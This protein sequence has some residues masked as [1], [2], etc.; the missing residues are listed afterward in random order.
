[1]RNTDRQSRPKSNFFFFFLFNAL[2]LEWATRLKRVAS[3]NAHWHHWSCNPC[4]TRLPSLDNNN[5]NIM[6]DILLVRE[7]T[8]GSDLTD[9]Q[10]KYAIRIYFWSY[11]LTSADF[12]TRECALLAMWVF[13]RQVPSLQVALAL[14]LRDRH[15]HET[16]ADNMR[17]QHSTGVSGSPP[18]LL[19]ASEKHHCNHWPPQHNL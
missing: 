10:I 3:H 8:T 17:P 9:D 11:S 2:A 1:M 15:G 12:V 7:Q 13:Q 16:P 6:E 19:Q 4:K 5:F 14:V 18:S